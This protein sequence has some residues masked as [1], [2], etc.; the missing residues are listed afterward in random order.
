MDISQAIAKIN[1]ASDLLKQATELLKETPKPTTPVVRK[2]DMWIPW[3]IRNFANITYKDRGPYSTKSKMPDGVVI[4]YNAGRGAGATTQAEADKFVKNLITYLHSETYKPDGSIKKHRYGTITI[5]NLGRVFQ[6]GP[7]S[8]SYYHAGDT[9]WN[10]YSQLNN[11]FVGIDLMSWGLVK[12]KKGKFYSYPS[13][14]SS[15]EV[16]KERV[17]YAGK[18]TG[19]IY[20]SHYET[21]SDAARD[22]LLKVI[23]WLEQNFGWGSFDNVCGHD[24]CRDPK[25]DKQD[26]GYVMKM[27]GN[28]IR[29]KLK[30]LKLAEDEALSLLADLDQSD[31]QG[32]FFDHVGREEIG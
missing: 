5:D 21:V 27:N 11:K 32:D 26:P 29:A 28:Q 10:G 19:I 22:S 25:G 17:V 20:P 8:A 31:E 30:E 16:P 14:Y 9:K 18:E 1:G 6:N 2:P 15:I 23:V 7:L 13:D 12:E 24:E 4:H 3:A